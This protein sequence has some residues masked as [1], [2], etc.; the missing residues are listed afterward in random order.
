MLFLRVSHKFVRQRL[1]GKSWETDSGYRLP[2]DQD[3][4]EQVMGHSCGAMGS[5]DGAA[6]FLVSQAARL[7]GEGRCVSTGRLVLLP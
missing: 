6:D 5:G 3:W 2:E 4:P 7:G 1:P